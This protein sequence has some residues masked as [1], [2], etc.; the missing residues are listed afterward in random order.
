MRFTLP[1]RR[2]DTCAIMGLPA[3]IDFANSPEVRT[4]LLKLLNA[5]A[6]PIVLDMSCT[7]FC[8]S[9]G[10]SAIFRA[11]QRACAM[12]TRIVLATP[13]RSVRK[14]FRILGLDRTMSVH[15]SVDEALA[16]V[17]EAD[18]TGPESLPFWAHQMHDPTVPPRAPGGSG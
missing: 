10:A 16:S 1:V 11:Y 17:S 2:L 14:V 13:S 8:D 7:S 18:R 3:E 12:G 5:G 6:G 9:S 4:E 15:P